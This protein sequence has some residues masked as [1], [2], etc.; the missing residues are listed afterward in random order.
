MCVF[1]DG[2]MNITM[3]CDQRGSFGRLSAASAWFHMGLSTVGEREQAISRALVLLSIVQDHGMDHLW[4]GGGLYRSSGLCYPLQKNDGSDKQ[5]LAWRI[6]RLLR[7]T[8]TAPPPPPPPPPPP[9][10]KGCDVAE[11]RTTTPTVH[12]QQRNIDTVHHPP[13]LSPSP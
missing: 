13:R 12:K 7:A 1:D 11:D 10:K 8:N 5:A 9:K 6:Y 4:R 2:A 3:T